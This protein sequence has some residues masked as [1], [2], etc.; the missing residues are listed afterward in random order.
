MTS[1]LN[2]SGEVRKLQ[3]I[4]AKLN[5]QVESAEVKSAE[6]TQLTESVER[7]LSAVSDRLNRDK[8]LNELLGPL[9]KK[10]RAVM[11]ELLQNVKT[12][13]LDEGFKKYIPAVL[14][15]DTRT[16]IQNKK[17][18]TLKESVRTAKTGNKRASIAQTEEEKETLAEIQVM[19]R[20]A[21]IS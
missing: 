17:R 15:A 19:Q 1:H 21:G 18:S 6:Q 8:K 4:V 9:G 5:E 20:M 16:V 12:D 3:D 14:N 11:G 2:E 13:K 10:E 7:K